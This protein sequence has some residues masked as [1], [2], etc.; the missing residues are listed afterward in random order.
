MW[1]ALTLN[2][3][4]PRLQPGDPAEVMVRNLAGKDGELNPTQVEAIRAMLGAPTGSLLSQYVDYLQ[5]LV[6]G[7]LGLSFTYFPFPV[8]QVIGQAVP[9]TMPWSG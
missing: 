1:A 6:H 9:W 2:F 4:I 7:D 8:T 3:L 5:H